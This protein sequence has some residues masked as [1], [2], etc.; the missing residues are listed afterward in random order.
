MTTDT[1]EPKHAVTV[2]WLMNDTPL[3]PKE[4]LAIGV[5]DS[6]LL[7]TSNAKLRKMLTESN[8]GESV[9]GGGLSDELL[10]VSMCVCMC[11]YV[12]VCTCVCVSPGGG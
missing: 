2:N 12:C 7:G 5:L 11:V 4:M 6:L 10:Q 3:S 1:E 8:L 9:T